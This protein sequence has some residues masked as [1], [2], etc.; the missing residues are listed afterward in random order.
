MKTRI[1][2][3]G[4]VLALCLSPALAA[5][6][7]RF[8]ATQ[9]YPGYADVQ[10]SDWF[11]SNARLCYEIGLMTGSDKG[12]E[13]GKTMRCSELV[14]IAARMREAATGVAIVYMDPVPGGTLPWYHSFAEYLKGAGVVLP[15]DL[16]AE[17]TRLDFVTLLAAVLP[18]ALL[19][20]INSE[21]TLPDTDSADVLRFY[22]A[23]ILTGN[24]KYGTFSPDKTL[25]RAEAAAMVSRVARENLRLPF[26]PTDYS[27]F[28]AAGCKPGDVFFQGNGNTVTAEEYLT[29]VN[30][31]VFTLETACVDSGIEFNWFNTYGDTTFLDYV[32][33]DLLT[34]IGVTG[35]MGTEL[36]KRFDVQVYYSRWLDLSPH[37]G[38]R[39]VV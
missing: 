8:P 9:E 7:E 39:A 37:G 31:T 21:F 32:K 13:P 36:Y 4:L 6:E 3:L 25:T 19:S 28:L 1:F 17:A 23:G 10:E 24:D 34:A 11:Y 30:E 33:N 29:L 26:S 14:T 27:P 35:D 2:A 5:A 12:F 15:Q 16:E 20:P 22:R 38:T 18:E